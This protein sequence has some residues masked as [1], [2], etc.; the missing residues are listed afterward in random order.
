MHGTT[1][2]KYLVCC[3]YYLPF[4][5]YTVKLR[6]TKWNSKFHATRL[7]SIQVTRHRWKRK[8]HH[9]IKIWLFV[10]Q[11][12]M[13]RFFVSIQYPF[14]EYNR[15]KTELRTHPCLPTAKKKKNF[16]PDTLNRCVHRPLH[17]RLSVEYMYFPTAGRANNANYYSVMWETC[18]QCV[19]TFTLTVCVLLS[20]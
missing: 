3:L 19:H 7:Y 4:T 15:N 10:G 2:I 18:D 17:S 11:R 5:L 14:T 9:N 20:V 13:W 8:F 1:N 16:P 6:T 12:K